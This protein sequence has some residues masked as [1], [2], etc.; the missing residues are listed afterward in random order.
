MFYEVLA[1]F[2]A[3]I[4]ERGRPVIFDATANRRAYRDR[5]AWSAPVAVK[6]VRPTFRIAGR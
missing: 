3:S 4:V 1:D 2:G 5:M 6:V